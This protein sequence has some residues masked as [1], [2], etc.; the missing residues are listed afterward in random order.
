MIEVNGI[1]KSYNGIEVLKGVSLEVPEGKITTV[2]GAS[3]AGKTT[4]LQIMACLEK[5]DSG[6]VRYDGIDVTTLKDKELSN[7]RNRR[8]GLVFQ[9]NCLLPEFTI[10][11]NVMLP[12]LIAGTA[13]NA[14]RGEA[15]RM[16]T[17]LGLADRL[18]H[19]PNELS[20]GEC[21]RAAVARAMINRP[22]VI[23]ADEP[24][25]SLDT[26]NRRALHQIFFDLRD[27][28]GTTFVIVTHD[29]TLASDSDLIVQLKDGAVEEIRYNEK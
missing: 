1:H 5:A 15:E 13:R 17:R 12:A 18:R 3:G 16:L 22:A 28:L 24:S 27:E 11:E 10:T 21:Q 19:R 25:G 14:A 4:L 23:L 26:G 29:E 2:V 7:F 8:V 6:N 9:Q 20:G